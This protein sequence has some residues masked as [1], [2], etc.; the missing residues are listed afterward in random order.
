MQLRYPS[1]VFL[2][3]SKS[4]LISNFQQGEY[5]TEETVDPDLINAGKET[6]T[7]LPGA[8]YF[9]SDESFAMIRG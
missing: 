8:S 9:A 7:A 4:I 2:T 3:W 1:I 6:V 5:P